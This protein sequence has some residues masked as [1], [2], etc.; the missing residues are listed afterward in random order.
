MSLNIAPPSPGV[1]SDQIYTSTDL[2]RKT[3]EV[4]NHAV[5]G[6]VTIS[7]NGEL[8]AIVKREQAA[9]LFQSQASS[10]FVVELLEMVLRS[11]VGSEIPEA[12][13]WVN[14][15]N[16]DEKRAMCTE[17][18]TATR[19]ALSAEGDWVSVM[20]V[21][22][23]WRE[24]GIAAQSPQLEEAMAQPAAHSELPPPTS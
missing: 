1:Y 17:V 6:P 8:F 12:Y 5:N 10:A 14:A 23:E 13:S 11:I 3:G 19:I 7:R 24:S 20:D 4:L 18:V 22:H 15:F 21:I 9:H 16:T 2:S